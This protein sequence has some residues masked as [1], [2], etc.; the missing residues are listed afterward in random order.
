M[1]E[2]GV[3]ED[4]PTG[5]TPHR[6]AFKVIDQWPLTESR[7]IIL[8]AS[9]VRIYPAGEC[10]HL[11]IPR[12]DEVPEHHAIREVSTPDADETEVLRGSEAPLS[13]SL[14]SL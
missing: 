6:R 1:I 9:R 5:A 11:H 14:A 4:V 10:E 2:Q 13:A 8:R 3:Q 12:E 7:E